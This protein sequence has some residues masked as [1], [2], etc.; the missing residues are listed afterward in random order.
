MIL[1]ESNVV[2]G[3]TSGGAIV[4][5]P[6]GGGS[7]TTLVDSLSNDAP[8]ALVIP[9]VTDG[10]FV[11]YVSGNGM[12][13]AI[14]LDPASAGVQP[15][16]IISQSGALFGMSVVG[17]HLLLSTGSDLESLSLPASAGSSASLLA[18]GLS[19][20]S[21][22]FPCGASACWLD[23]ASNLLGEVDPAGGCATTITD[24]SKHF[25]Q[26]GGVAF[27]GATF[28]VGGSEYSSLSGTARIVDRGA[29][30]RIPQ[31]GGLPVDVVVTGRGSSVGP[32]FAVDDECLYY[33]TPTGIYSVYKAAENAVTP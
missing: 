9:P 24:F 13:E 12:V 1:G 30:A 17:Q 16:P 22:V 10:T 15:T 29:I 19:S 33:S 23:P 32:S 8:L 14:P 27:D 18:P 26:A 31:Q 21:D 20:G 7:P 4:S 11:Y 3:G 6:R 25:A 2:D 28:F 5:L